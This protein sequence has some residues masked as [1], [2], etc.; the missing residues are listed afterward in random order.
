MPAARRRWLAA[1]MNRGVGRKRARRP[2]R[3]TAAS[4]RCMSRRPRAHVI[5]QDSAASVTG[6]EVER[7][8]EH[9]RCGISVE[10]ERLV[11]PLFQS[12][13]SLAIQDRM[14]FENAYQVRTR[15]VSTWTKSDAG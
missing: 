13:D 14:S 7:H 8:C 2:A 6:V 3:T 5:V 12:F 1:R 9:E 4:R 10:D 11:S 15:P